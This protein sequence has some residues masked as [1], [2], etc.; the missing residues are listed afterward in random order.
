MLVNHCPHWTTSRHHH[1]HHHDGHH[2]TSTA[3]IIRGD[4][5]YS[6]FLLCLWVFSLSSLA[7][8]SLAGLTYQGE[9]LYVY[10]RQ[11]PY[12]PGTTAP[13]HYILASIRH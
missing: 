1:C 9:R 13:P 12:V 7:D 5:I 3:T 2:Y 6:L 4:E 10:L 11:G 8:P